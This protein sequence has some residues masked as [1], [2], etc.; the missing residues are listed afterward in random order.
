VGNDERQ[1][2]KFM[3]GVIE[4]LHGVTLEQFDRHGRQRAVDYVFTSP[5][6]GGAVE[7]TTYQ[8]S[9]AAAWF[10]K[11]SSNGVIECASPR[12]WAVTVELGMKLDHLTLRLPSIVA[13]CDRYQVDHPTRV[14]ATDWDA[15]VQW[16]VTTGLNLYPSPASSPGTV[17]V[18]MPPT[19]GFPSDEGFDR[20]LERLLCDTKIANKLRKLRA[21]S[22]VTERH[23]A[24]GVDLYGSGFDL[25]DN[26]LMSRGHVPQY[27]PP[28][29]IV[30]TH[31]WLN[32]GGWDV[33][34][35]TRPTGWEWR[36][37]PRPY[38]RDPA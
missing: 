16:F 10:S 15:D 3:R 27:M 9:R 34:T 31:I 11:L 26:L 28:D 14:P 38:Q 36:T 32:A 12:G 19:I 2:E 33:L 5:S 24:I 37:L 25:I 1:S 8:D 13:A 23:L 20:D 22:S 29:D 21:H 7:I 30:A 35:W 4:L 17:R 6:G 18:Q